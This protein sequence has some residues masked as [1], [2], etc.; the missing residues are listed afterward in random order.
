LGR[1]A[2]VPAFL[3]CC[4]Y[5]R[6]PDYS[7]REGAAGYAAVA[8][9]LQ[10]HEARAVAAVAA[11]A[12]PGGV[13]TSASRAPL[14]AGRLFY[15]ATPPEVF[16]LAAA[17]ISTHLSPPEA[18]ADDDNVPS[19]VAF[20]ELGDVPLASAAAQAAQAAPRR[21]RAGGDAAAGGGEGGADAHPA[22]R[23]GAAVT[24]APLRPWVRVIIEKPF[25]RDGAT[26]GALETALRHHFPEEVRAGVRR[27][28]TPAC[29]T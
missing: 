18:A 4:L 25:G 23:A 26:A 21:L 24:V 10:A 5:F 2:Q 28:T 22:A 8:E 20:S 3:A 29:T 13:G 17:A 27:N 9:A 19:V 15:L 12:A 14:R 1:H 6:L 11:A 16:P 7:P